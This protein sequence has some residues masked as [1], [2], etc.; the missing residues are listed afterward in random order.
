[1]SRVEKLVK[2]LLDRPA[3]FTYEELLKILRHFGYE[4]VKTGKT[5]GSRRAFIH[6]QTMH[7]LRIHKPHPERTI[8]RYVLDY[9]IEELRGKHLL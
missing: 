3:D 7:I 2:R 9:L 6:K 5:A 1:M 8:K 4:E